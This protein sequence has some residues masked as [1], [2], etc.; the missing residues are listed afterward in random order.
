[1]SRKKT[2]KVTLQAVGRVPPE[3]VM[4]LTADQADARRHL[5]TPVKDWHDKRDAPTKRLAFTAKEPVLFKAGEELELDLV[6]GKVPPLLADALRVAPE[7][8]PAAR[9]EDGDTPEMAEMRKMFDASYAALKKQLDDA[10]AEIEAARSEGHK[11]GR[12]E[13]LAE[14][15]RRNAL[16]DTADAAAAAADEARLAHESE[17]DPEKRKQLQAKLDAALEAQ[18]VADKAVDDLPELKA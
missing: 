8:A 6:D 10:K 14:V 5:L 1:M 9:N 2:T 7:P 16:I 4:H 13:L 11:E 12:A 18:E 3:V 15:E 17:T